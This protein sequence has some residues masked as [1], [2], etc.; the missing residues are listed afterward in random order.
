M[1]QQRWRPLSPPPPLNNDKTGAQGRRQYESKC[2]K[3]YVSKYPGVF[4]VSMESR[5]KHPTT[6]CY[7][8]PANMGLSENHHSCHA[9]VVR[10]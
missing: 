5:G 2:L 10:R 8:G 7:R 6:P 4:T 3:V 9:T 1:I